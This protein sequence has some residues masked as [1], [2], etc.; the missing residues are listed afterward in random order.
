MTVC[1]THT[2]THNSQHQQHT[3]TK[4]RKNSVKEEEEY[5]R[6]SLNEIVFGQ[7]KKEKRKKKTVGTQRDSRMIRGSREKK[8]PARLTNRKKN[9]FFLHE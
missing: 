8:P 3:Y 1:A 9:T 2:R 6:Q 5:E 7:S 4:M